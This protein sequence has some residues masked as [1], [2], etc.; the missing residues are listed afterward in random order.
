MT[1][2]EGHFTAD[3]GAMGLHRKLIYDKFALKNSRQ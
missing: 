1:D 2:W 3:R